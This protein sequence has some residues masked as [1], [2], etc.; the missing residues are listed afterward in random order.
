MWHT[1]KLEW[2]GCSIWWH[3]WRNSWGSSTISQIKEVENLA[4]ENAN[5]NIWFACKF[6]AVTELRKY[7]FQN[8]IPDDTSFHAQTKA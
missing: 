5:D 4:I 6:Q 3:I 2:S 8:K 1:L 7:L